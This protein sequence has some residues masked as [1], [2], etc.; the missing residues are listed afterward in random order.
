MCL[1][2]ILCLTLPQLS[3]SG[4]SNSMMAAAAA[5]GLGGPPRVETAVA[6]GLPPPPTHSRLPPDGHEFPPE[7]RDP[8]KSQLQQ[9]RNTMHYSRLVFCGAH[10]VAIIQRLSTNL[11]TYLVF[12]N[13]HVLSI[14]EANATLGI[15]ILTFYWKAMW[16][17]SA[18]LYSNIYLKRCPSRLGANWQNCTH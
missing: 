6:A 12:Q 4:T 2:Y 7:Y 3:R 17:W 5:A 18:N 16:Y 15:K 9:V 10:S 14:R 11:S 1:L 13:G 8:A